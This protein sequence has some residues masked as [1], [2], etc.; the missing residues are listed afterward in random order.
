MPLSKPNGGAPHQVDTTAPMSAEASALVELEIDSELTPG[1]LIGEYRIESKIGE[2]GMASVYAGTQPV[3][4]K[5]VAV[6][7][8]NRQLCVDPVQVERF[9]QEARAVCQIGHPNIVDVFAF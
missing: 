4:G 7:V 9:V 3:I 5:K 2:G 6:K 1:T 8:M